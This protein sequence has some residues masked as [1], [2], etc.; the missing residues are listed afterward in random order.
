MFENRLKT[1]TF[2]IPQII[3][4]NKIDLLKSKEEELIVKYIEVYT[5]IGVKCLQVSAVSRQGLDQVKVL[6]SGK[7]SLISGHSGVGKSTIINQLAP[8]NTD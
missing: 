3:I 6:L 7:K 2:R 8:N 5:S 1:K 4:F